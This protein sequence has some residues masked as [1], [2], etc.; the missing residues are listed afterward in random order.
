MQAMEGKDGYQVLSE[1]R[2]HA[3]DYVWMVKVRKSKEILM[4]RQILFSK[5]SRI[6]DEIQ[7]IYQISQLGNPYLRI[8]RY[9]DKERVG[10]GRIALNLYLD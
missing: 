6:D 9:Y 8:P 5:N 7:L 2:N 3:G 10:D 1:Y 4:K